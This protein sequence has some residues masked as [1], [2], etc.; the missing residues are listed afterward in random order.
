MTERLIL[1]QQ[2]F[3]H[4][5]NVV[6]PELSRSTGEYPVVFSHCW[7]R[8]LYDNLYH[9]CWYN[10]IDST[11]GPAYKQLTEKELETLLVWCHEITKS[12]RLAKL[13]NLNS[14]RWRS[15]YV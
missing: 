11:K 14:L 15:E 5:V 4:Q 9:T 8:I 7:S 13:M 1:L 10:K 3:L 12:P 2:E 6:L